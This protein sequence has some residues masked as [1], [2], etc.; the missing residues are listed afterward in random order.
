MRSCPKGIRGGLAAN[1]LQHM[2]Y[3]NVRNLM[4]GLEGWN[5]AK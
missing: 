2:G 1:T 3:T 4:D 5:K